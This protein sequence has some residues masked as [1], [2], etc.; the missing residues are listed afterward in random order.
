[1]SLFSDETAKSHKFR[2]FKGKLKKKSKVK[3]L[4][5]KGRTLFYGSLRGITDAVILL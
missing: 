1:M 5:F 4:L 2:A 3:T